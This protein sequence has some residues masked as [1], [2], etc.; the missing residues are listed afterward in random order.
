MYR[1]LGVKL[2]L[3]FSKCPCKTPIVNTYSRRGK[4]G[5]SSPQVI[6]FVAYMLLRSFVQGYALFILRSLGIGREPSSSSL[7]YQ[8]ACKIFLQ[9]GIKAVRPRKLEKNGSKKLEERMEVTG[10]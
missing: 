5:N 4:E 1:C 2:Y 9:I 7:E 8:F 6:L 3:I 10:R